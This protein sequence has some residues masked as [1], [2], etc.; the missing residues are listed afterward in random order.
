M[1]SHVN[2][3]DQLLDLKEWILNAIEHSEIEDTMAMY[4][5]CVLV[6]ISVDLSDPSIPKIIR[7][8]IEAKFYTK[9]ENG[10]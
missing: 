7:E 4:A 9:D 2:T 6:K 1:V 5:P 8:P 10:S 3:L